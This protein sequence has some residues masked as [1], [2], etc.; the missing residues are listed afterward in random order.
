[1]SPGDRWG[2]FAS[3]LDEAERRARLRCLRALARVLAGPRSA[4]LCQRLAE[5]EADPAAADEV[6]AALGRLP[7][8]DRRQILATFAGL[9]PP[10]RAA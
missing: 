8:V 6:L 2:P 4:E 1:M 3:G 10:V 5:A 7:P 9:Y